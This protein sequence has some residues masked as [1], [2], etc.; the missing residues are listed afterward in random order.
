LLHFEWQPTAI[1]KHSLA[2]GESGGSSATVLHWGFFSAR[3]E[4]T[5]R[6]LQLRA[7]PDYRLLTSVHHE[8]RCDA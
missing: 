3:P 2:S 7:R 8:Y 5:L 4:D 1:A 6:T